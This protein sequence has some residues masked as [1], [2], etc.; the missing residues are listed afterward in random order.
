M[1]TLFRR[2]ILINFAV[3]PHAMSARL[4]DHLTADL[5]G[6]SAYLSIVVA[7]MEDMRPAFLPGFMGVSYTQVVY[8]AVVRCGELRGVTFLRSDANNRLM[9]AAGNAMTFFRFHHADV[10]WQPK[11]RGVGFALRPSDGAAASISADYTESDIPDALP[12]TSR[13]SSLTQAQS[14]LTELYCAFG[15]RRPDG[16]I[17]QVGIERSPWKGRVLEGDGAQYEAMSGGALFPVGAAELDSVFMVENL[18]YHWQ[19]LSLLPPD[20]RPPTQAPE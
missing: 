1:K 9:V 8:R 16:R 19:R 18:H 13:F 17:E 7:Q 20:K 15:N 14:F 2:C 4:P 12:S 11:S 3:D 10:Q 6:G 5:H